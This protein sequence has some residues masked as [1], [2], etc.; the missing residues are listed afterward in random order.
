MFGLVEDHKKVIEW[1]KAEIEHL[2]SLQLNPYDEK[3]QEYE[4]MIDRL[5]RTVREEEAGAVYEPTSF[6]CCCNR[7]Y[8]G[9]GFVCPVCMNAIMADTIIQEAV[10]DRAYPVGQ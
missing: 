8:F 6:C 9:T 2:E 3:F 1:L 4:D 10:R 5:K 7:E